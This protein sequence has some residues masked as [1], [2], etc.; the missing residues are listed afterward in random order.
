MEAADETRLAARFQAVC[1]AEYAAVLTACALTEHSA[2]ALLWDD[3]LLGIFANEGLP[4]TTR[5]S[6]REIAQHFQQLAGALAAWA[7]QNAAGDMEHARCWPRCWRGRW[8]CAC[9]W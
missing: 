1:G 2:A 7:G 5:T 3:P 9:G 8:I 4:A 6:W